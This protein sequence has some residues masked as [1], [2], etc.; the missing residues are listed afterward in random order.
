M[1][2]FRRCVKAGRRC[3]ISRDTATYSATSTSLLA[4]FSFLTSRYLS[5]RSCS[6]I[7]SVITIIRYTIYLIWAIDMM[8]LIDIFFYFCYHFTMFILIWFFFLILMKWICNRLV[9]HLVCKLFCTNIIECLTV[10]LAPW[11]SYWLPMLHVV[12]SPLGNFLIIVW[13]IV[14]PD[15]GVL[16]CAVYV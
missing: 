2:V 13:R 5:T 12:G 16:A 4:S 6:Y 7:I 15:L 9:M 8:T 10:Q 3:R 11:L 1:L 14:V